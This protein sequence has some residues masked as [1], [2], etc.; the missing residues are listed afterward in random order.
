MVLTQ[1]LLPVIL[2]TL[3][4]GP[5]KAGAQVTTPLQ[6]LSCYNDYRSH[7]TCRWASTREAQQLINLTLYRRLNEDPPKPVSCDL[8][9]DMA[10]LSHPCPGCV[11]RRCVIPYEIFVIADKDYF[12]FRPDRPLGTQLTITLTQHVQ[13]PAPKDLLIDT[14]GDRFLLT[15][16]VALP[17]SQGHWL[18]NLEFEVAYKRLQDSWEEASTLH[19]NSSRAVLGPEHLVPSSTYVARVRTHLASNSGLSGRPSQWSPEVRW[20]SQTG[21]T[22][23]AGAMPF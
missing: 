20:H 22:G 19:L 1:R 8:S 13:A 7:I 23:K 11:P 12:S 14:T 4:W 17:D 2:L 3:F 21:N 10:L 5:S 18:S 15:W 9:N 16:S 6:T